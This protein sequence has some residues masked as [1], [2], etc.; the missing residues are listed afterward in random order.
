MEFSAISSDDFGVN[1]VDNNAIG[2]RVA[3]RISP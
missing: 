2:P 1:L 3:L